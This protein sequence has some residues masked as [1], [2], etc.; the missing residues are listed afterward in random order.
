MHFLWFFIP[1][2]MQCKYYKSHLPGRKYD[3]L[4]KCTKLNTTLYAEMA[5]T[6]V[7]QCGING[8]WFVS[9]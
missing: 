9:I 7:N 2:C 8:K 4:A 6:N 3:D 5:R 1:G